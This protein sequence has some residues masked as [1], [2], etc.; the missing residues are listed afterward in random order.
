MADRVR[1]N[2]NGGHDDTNG[3]RTNSG[4]QGHDDLRQRIER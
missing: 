3:Q 4:M 2:N 1:A